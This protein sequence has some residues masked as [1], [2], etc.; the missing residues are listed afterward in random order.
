MAIYLKEF[1]TH[2]EYEQYINGSGAIL[3]NVS[4]CATEGDVHYN[5]FV[6]TRVV[7]KFNV[8]DTS[9]PTK[10]TN[11]IS[12]FSEIEIDGSKQ[13]SVTTGYTFDTVDEH[14]VKY[15]LTN[16]T[17]IGSSAFS[18]C[19]SLTSIVIP[20]SVTS[21]NSSAF[22]GC[23]SLTSINIPSGVT[24]I[25]ANVFQ[26]CSSLTSIDIPSGV[27]RIDSGAFQDC[28]SLTSIDIPSGVTS[29]DN[30]AFQYCTGLTNVT[31]NSTTPPTLGS[32]VFNYNASGRKIYVPAASVDEYKAASGWST[33]AND[34]EPIS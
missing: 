21:I 19:S 25:N 2:Q 18:R 8:T 4:I 13:P 1:S 20:D 16:P 10:I 32:N 17:S 11:D 27:A 29:I 33:Y 5:P 23:R 15:T 6:E 14:T 22:Y 28:S 12:S 26:G 9:N 3:P 30:Y 31:V 24:N 34:I 7:A